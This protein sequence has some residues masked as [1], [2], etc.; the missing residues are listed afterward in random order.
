LRRF[1]ITYVF[2]IST[3][4]VTAR[5]FATTTGPVTEDT[6]RGWENIVMATL[7]DGVRAG[8]IGFFELEA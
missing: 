6:I 1:L 8:V 2:G 7:P 4:Y 5:A 3:G